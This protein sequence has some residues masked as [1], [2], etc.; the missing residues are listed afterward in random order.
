MPINIIIAAL[1]PPSHRRLMLL[2][3]VSLHISFSAFPPIILIGMQME[4]NYYI[5][6]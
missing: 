1:A 2:P 4:L 3:M 6:E 5:S